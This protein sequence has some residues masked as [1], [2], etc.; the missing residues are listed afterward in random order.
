[1]KVFF[2]VALYNFRYSQDS[3]D[4]SGGFA[5]IR[6]FSP[7][8]RELPCVHCESMKR[9]TEVILPE[10]ANQYGTLFAGNALNL[11]LKAAFLAASRHTRRDVVMAGR[12]A[13]RPPRRPHE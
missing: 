13:T 3:Q 1:M 9:I 10:H 7:S 12:S 4:C 11:L 5:F 2:I 8:G 6:H